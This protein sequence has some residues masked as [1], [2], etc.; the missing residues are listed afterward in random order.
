[1]ED[2]VPIGR[3]PGVRE[4]GAREPV[5]DD[6]R[7]RSGAEPQAASWAAS[8]F[9]GEDAA[10]V[11]DA[12]DAPVPALGLEKAAAP[13]VQ[14]ENAPAPAVQP[15]QPR[16]SRPLS[17]VQP[18]TAPRALA[19]SKRFASLRLPRPVALLALAASLAVLVAIMTSSALGGAAARS[20]PKTRAAS[21]A[22]TARF[23]D[24]GKQVNKDV[25]MLA[26][27][28]IPPLAQPRVRTAKAK[29]AKRHAAAAQS[30]SYSA[31]PTY[32]HSASTSG[33]T[34]EIRSSPPPARPGPTGIV[35]LVGAGTSPSG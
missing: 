11:Q 21:R 23:T 19:V 4:P 20:A 18:P 22:H 13:A 5:G 28:R 24:P 15:E 35:S 6:L 33:A 10:N 32:A 1:V 29:S 2:L 27:A 30:A 9:W 25:E 17:R 7:G 14:P 31:S 12:L 3:E 26:S 8:D 16:P 34:S